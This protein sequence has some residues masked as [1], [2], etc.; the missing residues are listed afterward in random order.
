MPWTYQLRFSGMGYMPYH[1]QCQ[2]YQGYRVMNRPNSLVI[3]DK[4]DAEFREMVAKRLGMK[5]GNMK[6][7]IEQTHRLWIDQKA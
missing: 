1:Q 2:Q 3:N 4:L 5:K 6:I 7:A